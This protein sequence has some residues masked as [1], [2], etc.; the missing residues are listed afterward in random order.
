MKKIT[1]ALS[2]ISLFFFTSSSFGWTPD[3]D[4]KE[5]LE[6]ASAITD[7]KAED[8]SLANWFDTAVGYAVFPSVKKGGIGWGGARGKGLLI[9][10]DTI[11][12]KVTLTQVTV[13]F[14]LGGQVYAEFIFFKDQTALDEFTRG[15]FEMGAQVSAVALSAGASADA[16]Y[17]DGVAVFTIAGGGLMYEASI[18]GQNFE[19][20]D[21]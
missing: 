12:K 20:E 11:L 7:A 1:L 9:Q 14:Q 19:I 2:V 5:Q 21:Y 10:G 13:G 6:V 3:S 4:D 17:S 15:N 8:P 18:G 16:S